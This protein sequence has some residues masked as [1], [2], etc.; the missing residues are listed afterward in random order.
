LDAS[1]VAEDIDFALRTMV[2]LGPGIHSWRCEQF[3]KLNELGEA[4]RPIRA[5]LDRGRCSA[6]KVASSHV[7]LE[8]LMLSAFSIAWPDAQITELVQK[9]ATVIGELP[10]AGIYREADVP[11]KTTRADL[12]DTN[13]QWID[14]ICNRAPPP[15]EQQQVIYQKTLDEVE[16]GLI[17]ALVTKA[18]MDARHGVGQWRPLIRFAVWQAGAGKWRVIDNGRTALHNDAMSTGERIHTTSIDMGVA[19]IR[20][21]RE[22][23]GVPLV[24]PKAV[25][26]STQDMKKAFRQIPIKED[27]QQFHIIAIYSH[28]AGQWVFGELKGLAFGLGAAV[29]EF[30]RIPIYLA[31]LARRWLAIPVLN[32]YDDFRIVDVEDSQASG[33]HMFERLIGWTGWWLDPDKHQGPAPEIKFLGTIEDASGALAPD[34]VRLHATEERRTTLLSEV[35]AARSTGI[36]QPGD[37]AHIVGKLIHYGASLPGKLGAGLLAPLSAHARE[38]TPNLADDA[39]AALAYHQ[40]LLAIPRARVVPLGIDCHRPV[41]VI[42]DA[43]WGDDAIKPLVGKV[44]FLMFGRD[45]S[46]WWGGVVDI[47]ADSD[48]I[49][50]LHMRKTQIMAAELLGPLL[51]LYFGGDELDH[52]ACSFFIDNL[53]GMCSLVKGNSKKSDLSAVAN[54]VHVE[55]VERDCRPWFDYVESASNAADGGSRVGLVDPVAKALGI[56]LVQCRLPRLPATFPYCSPSEWTRWWR[57]K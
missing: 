11:P 47:T 22:L 30:N 16:C 10:K 17:D 33:D 1:V 52:S 21:L 12:M 44:C 43:S 18:Q 42:T 37:A 31:A 2:A 25:R 14:E 19:V 57:A 55:L 36:C 20:K 5:S 46:R 13:V 6:S 51:A 26:S 48:L 50:K 15:P 35:T 38:S 27:D 32:F 23:L 39:L 8:R 40:E 56:P 4:L 3:R 28:V 29:L 9:G 24:G 41:S 53:S 54:A 49:R 7:H 34:A 45:R